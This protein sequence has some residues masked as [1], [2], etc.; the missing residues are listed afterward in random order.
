MGYY[1]SI[2]CIASCLQSVLLVI[3]V[4]TK[5]DLKMLKWAVI[6]LFAVLLIS[7]VGVLYNWVYWSLFLAL[8][9]LMGIV[10]SLVGFLL[11]CA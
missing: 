3:A 8:G 7:S 11:V 6:A 4:V 9:L 1:S 10:T 2:C 5:L